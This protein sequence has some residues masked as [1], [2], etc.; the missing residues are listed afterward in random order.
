MKQTNPYL[1]FYEERLAHE[2]L[3]K[4]RSVRHTQPSHYPSCC[5]RTDEWIDPR[6]RFSWAVPDEKAIAKIAEVSPNGVVEIGAG[7]GYWTKMLRQAGVDVISYD[8]AP[9]NSKWHKGSWDEV[10]FGD[11]TSVIGHPDRTLLTVW[12]EYQ[13]EWSEAMVSLY[14]GSTVVYVGEGYGGCT[15][16]DGMH[17]ILGADAYCWCEGKCTCQPK[18]EQLFVETDTVEIPQWCGLHDYLYV[19]NRK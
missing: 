16:N 11:H 13:A 10:I 18:A 4:P 3:C 12:P 2:I 9:V 7:A 6:L 19:Y 14:E 17:A 15:G 5:R 8:P 1:S